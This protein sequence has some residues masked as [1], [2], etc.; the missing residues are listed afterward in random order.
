MFQFSKS[1]EIILASSFKTKDIVDVKAITSSIIKFIDVRKKLNHQDDVE[2][3]EDIEKVLKSFSSK[4]GSI[5]ISKKLLIKTAVGIAQREWVGKVMI[6][7]LVTAIA[8]I[9]N[10]D[11]EDIEEYTNSEVMFEPPI[12]DFIIPTSV[13]K[14]ALLKPIYHMKDRIDVLASALCTYDNIAIQ[15][16]IGSGRKS[17][18][19]SLI[20]EI[21]F[22]NYPLLYNSRFLWNPSKEEL[23]VALADQQ[24][25]H[26]V[27][28]MDPSVPDNE[29]MSIASSDFVLEANSK[30]TRRAKFIFIFNPSNQNNPMQFGLSM[31]NVNIHTIQHTQTNE[32]ET[33]QITKAYAQY[34]KSIVDFKIDEEALDIIVKASN[35][36]RGDSSQPSRSIDMLVDFVFNKFNNVTMDKNRIEVPTILD[37]SINEL[38]AEQI[39]DKIKN[40]TAY[41]IIKKKAT[42]IHLSLPDAENY[43]STKFKIT[44]EVMATLLSINTREHL[45][46]IKTKITSYVFGQDGAVDEIVKALKR[47]AIGL[48]KMERPVSFLFVGST[49]TGKT[50]IAKILSKITLGSESNM[51]RFDMSEY[52][53]AHEVSKLIG[54]PPGYV[55]SNQPGRLSVEIQKNPHCVLLLDEIEKAHPD[56]LNIFL[57]IFDDGRLTDNHGKVVDFSKAI[58]IMTSNIG[59]KEAETESTTNKIGFQVSSATDNTAKDYSKKIMSSVEEYFKPEVLNRLSKIILFNKLGDEQF[60][61][62]IKA[63]MNEIRNTTFITL[64]YNEDQIADAILKIAKEKPYNLTKYNARELKRTII[65]HIEAKIIDAYDQIESSNLE[66]KVVD[67]KIEIGKPDV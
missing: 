21:S 64:K 35:R 65:D 20:R 58:I 25:S 23:T 33:L 56:I 13:V 55:G 30:V 5:P 19:L 11:A 14:S 22:G 3:T 15:G 18:I 46:N 17:L 31:A 8:I 6:F 43:I 36:L 9:T 24:G 45:R 61:L 51:I 41:K 34:L 47:R 16:E 63:R 1:V 28:I 27:S 10:Y 7:H 42:H 66:I 12:N 37:T 39:L 26:I 67:S 38:N 62:I 29:R 4:H 32:K 40:G 49:G 48:D 59:I 60:K 50:Y 57:Q 54:S 44:P 53:S 2:D 52:G